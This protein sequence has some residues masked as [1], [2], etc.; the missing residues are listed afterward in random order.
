[1]PYGHH[2]ITGN[3]FKD[4]CVDSHFGHYLDI[5]RLFRNGS[6]RC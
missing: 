6:S 3:A 5:S 1:M 2:G 4:D